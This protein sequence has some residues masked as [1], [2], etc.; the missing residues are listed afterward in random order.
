MAEA[1]EAAGQV[2]ILVNNAG[3]VA[4]QVGRPLEE[5]SEE[6]W[7]G[8]LR[9]EPERSLQLLPGRGTGNEGGGVGDAS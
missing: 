4:G 1:A 3:G 9:R 6:D 2:D 5:I 8:D 7:Q